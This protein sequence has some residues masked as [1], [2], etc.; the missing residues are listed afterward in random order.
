MNTNLDPSEMV[1]AALERGDHGEIGARWKWRETMLKPF[2]LHHKNAHYR[3]AWENM[4]DHEYAQ[5]FLWL[6]TMTG[7]QANAIRGEKATAKALF[8]ATEWAAKEGAAQ[9]TVA[10][11]MVALMK[12]IRQDAER[13][14]SIAPVPRGSSAPNA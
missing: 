4:T 5:T 3:L 7:E 2:S 9:K 11:E 14:E 13:A 12:E 1:A 10:D 6:L 8:D